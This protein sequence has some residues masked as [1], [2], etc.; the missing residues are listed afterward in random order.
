M[1]SFAKATF[2]VASYLAC[3]PTYPQKVY[4]TILAHHRSRGGRFDHLVDVGCGPG[5][6]A[7]SLS[8][9]FKSTTALDPSKKMVDV[10]LQPSDPSRPRIEYKVGTAES[11][12]EAGVKEADLVTAGQAAHWFDHK[13]TWAELSKVVRPG[14]TVAYIGYAELVFPSH[15]RLNPLFSHFSSKIIGAYWSQPGRSIVENLLDAVPFPVTPTT[16]PSSPGVGGDAS[17]EHLLPLDQIDEPPS[18]QLDDSGWDPTTA[19]RIRSTPTKPWLMTRPMSLDQFE[20]YL[21]SASAVHEYRQAHPEEKRGEG[22]GDVVD[23]FMVDIRNGLESE[24][25]VDKD[26]KGKF[27]VGWPLVV[28]MIKKKP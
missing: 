27:E 5:F 14:G 12:V 21:R 17:G 9:H 22:D 20:G 10:G 11:L 25:M 26:G 16:S 6:V 1:A 15:P 28:M 18:L 3:R 23:R 7:L 19:I 8:P 13:K 4:E 24:G 2:D